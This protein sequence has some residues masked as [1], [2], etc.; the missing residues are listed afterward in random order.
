MDT[1]SG[2]PHTVRHGTCRALQS[3][4]MRSN[5]SGD[6]SYLKASVRAWA[7]AGAGVQESESASA[8][9]REHS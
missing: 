6:T 3:S 8:W 9:V 7:W 4:A 5:C 1:W 2:S